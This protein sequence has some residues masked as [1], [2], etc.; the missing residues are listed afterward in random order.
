[1]EADEWVEIVP[2]LPKDE[3][4]G[5]FDQWKGEQERK[6]RVIALNHIR[7]DQILA[8]GGCLVRYMLKEVR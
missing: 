8:E 4:K 7:V 1:M 2:P 6:G 3:A 5:R